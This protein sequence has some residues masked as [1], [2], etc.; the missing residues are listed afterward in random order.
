M[1][2]EWVYRFLPA[3]DYP[4]RY[5]SLT[6][7]EFFMS[8]VGFLLLAF[9]NNKVGVTLLVLGLIA[10]LR[11]FKQGKHP[12]VLMLLVYWYLPHSLT[13]FFLPKLPASHLRVWVA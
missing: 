6:L 5:F 10:A 11:Y 4:K 9:A 1:Q 2:A 13:R 7:D 3:L 8:A 12:R